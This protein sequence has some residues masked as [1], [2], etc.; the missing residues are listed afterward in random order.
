MAKP[1]GPTVPRQDDSS[2]RDDCGAARKSDAPIVA[3]GSADARLGRQLVL[4]E[5]F[6]LSLYRALRDIATGSLRGVLDELILVETRHVAFWQEFFG[7]KHVTT[8]DPARRLKLVT[9]Y[10]TCLLFRSAAIHIVLEAIEVHGVRKYL[11]VWN[12][13]K[14]GSLGS[15]VREILEDEFKH[16]DMVVSGAAERHIN[17]EKVRNVFLGLNDGLVEILGAVSGFFAAF[18]RPTAVLAAGFTVAVAG[19]MSMAA[20]AYIGAGSEAEVRATEA[21]RR[22]FLGE[23]VP[24]QGAESPMA[25][26]LVVGVGYFAGAVVPVLP[27]LFGATGLLPTV[28]TAGAMIVAVSAIV[29]FISGMAVR[30]RIVLNLI[31]TGIAVVVTYTIGLLAKA[32]WGIAV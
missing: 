8:L 31:I 10:M 1:G 11:R 26:A 28:V 18:R 30:R 7:L 3:T 5:V 25:S 20:G 19:A 24:S 14:D 4:D 29:A 6:D 2:H 22:R 13:Y 9:L 15:A 23:K 21:E 12:R 17:P 16:E 32:V 27:V